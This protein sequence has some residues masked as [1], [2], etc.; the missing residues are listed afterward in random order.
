VVAV[1]GIDFDI[2]E[3]ECVGFLGPNGAGKSS[4]MGML[5]GRVDVTA[6]TLVVAG[7][8]VTR[9]GSAVRCLTG[10]VPQDDTTDHDL[11]VEGNLLSY[12]RYFGLRGRAARDRADELLD[13]F[14][15]ADRRRSRIEEL[16]GGL[17]RRLMIARGLVNAPRLLLLDEP[18]TGLDPQARQ[19]VWQRL[20]ALR[21]GGVTMVLT[22]HYMEEASS[23]CDRLIMM[24]QGKILLEGSPSRLVRE[25]AGEQVVEVLEPDADR[26]A[27]LAA[28]VGTL[29]EVEESADALYLYGPD[30][31]ALLD[32]VLGFGDGVRARLR[33]ANLEDVYLRL[34]GRDLAA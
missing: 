11:D 4:T 12:A 34:T 20:R 21:R 33:P 14:Q 27:A 30:G 1:D 23:L 15:L 18:T 13:F 3:G 2:R 26:R 17:R 31:R 9:E 25:R 22:T 19:A 28:R 8:D 7:L 16:S 29:A 6:G 24:G 32:R 5:Y 10:V